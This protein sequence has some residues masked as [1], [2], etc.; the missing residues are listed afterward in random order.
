MI[1]FPWRMRATHLLPLLA[2]LVAGPAVAGEIPSIVVTPYYVPTSIARAGSTVT[3]VS[4]EAIARSSAGSVAELLRTVPGV[5]VNEFGGAGGQALVGLRGGEPGHTLVLIDGVRVNDAA[6]AR[7][8]FDFAVLSLSNVE[9]IEILRGPQSALYGS[10]AMGGVINVITR[11]PSGS[12]TA[13]ATAEGGSYGTRRTTVS[14][15]GASGPFSLSASGTYFAT[16]GFSRVGDRDHGE[17]DGTEKYAGTVRGAIDGEG[18]IRFDFGVDVHHQASDI[19]KSAT[20]DAAGYTSVRDLTSGFGRLTVPAMDG[21]LTHTL[22]GFATETRRVFGEPT[23]DFFYYAR[24]VGLEYQGYLTLGRAGS[25]ILGGRFEQ[26]AASQART[27]KPSPVYDDTSLLYAGYALWQVPVDAHLNLSFAGRHDGEVGGTGFTTGRFTAVYDMPAIETRVRGSVGTGAKRPTAFQLAYNPALMPET[28][29][30]ADLGIE[31]T[32][33]DGRLTVS[34]TAFWNR[35]RNLIDFDGDFLT[36]TYKNIASAQTAGVEVAA[37]ATIVPGALTGT[38]T[39]TYLCARDLATG[40]PLERRPAHSGTLSLTYTGIE[41]LDA[42]LSATL[43]GARFNDDDATQPLP[44]YA[45]VDL[46]MNYQVNETM[47]VFARVENLLNASYQEVSGY[48]TA[49]LSV[50]GG[51]T[52]RH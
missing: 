1:T 14:A 27:D 48:N 15:S 31:R 6:S 51:L 30:G 23:R 20:V 4:H 3:V 5:T 49:G 35:F 16:N 38:A 33:A 8:E 12:L 24:D 19:D 36:G 44:A 45:R 47:A 9:R 21:R 29:V 11:R 13:S 22:T 18:G 43:V 34:A 7:D 28:S 10:D 2:A 41:N 25:L 17:P 40:L 32:L 37:S 50:Y 42:T 46:T 52:W 39:Y 26:T